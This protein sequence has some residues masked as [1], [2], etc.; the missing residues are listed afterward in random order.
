MGWQGKHYGDGKMFKKIESNYLAQIYHRNLPVR[1]R[2]YL[3]RRGIPNELVN[4]Y[5]LGWDGQRITIP[6]FNR[7]GKLAFFKLA[8]DPDDPLPGPKMI[9]TRGA[10]AELYGWDWILAKPASIIICEGEFDRLVLESHGFA[11]V[12]STAGAGT[13]RGEWAKEFLLISE[14]YICFDR[15]E[16]GQ[17]GALR[18]GR[19]IPH[20][21]LIT[22]PEEVGQGGDVTDFFVRLKKE[23]EGF[24]KLMEEAQPAPS[25]RPQPP[26]ALA[27]FPDSSPKSNDALN[28]RVERIKSRVPVATIIGQYVSLKSSG[29]SF[30]G[31]CPFHEDHHPS[32]V[33]YPA[34]G[35]F[36]CFGCQRHG[37]V[38][39]FL[40][41]IEHLSFS[42]ALD[43]LD[44]IKL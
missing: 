9:A 36:H 13:F 5:L 30:I 41:E 32:L 4:R 31:L 19:M 1:I 2:A 27:V 28:H 43:A 3:N 22:L 10:N 34:T 42:Q 20:A 37:D 39:E 25:S 35:T 29:H 8:K 23:K 16:A 44:Q 11:A 21:K 18:V 33:V 40:M 38:I 15:D 14:V 24:L 12:T 7:A 6:I 17:K 26:P